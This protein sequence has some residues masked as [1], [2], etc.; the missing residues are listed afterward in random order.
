MKRMFKFWLFSAGLLILVSSAS[1]QIKE[2]D[3]ADAMEKFLKSESGQEAIGKAAEAYFRN[4]EM[5][6][7]QKQ[8]RAMEE[9]LEEQ[10]KNP[11]KIEVGN[12]PV[13]G[14]KDARITVIEFSDYQCPYCRRGRD[15]MR[16]LL[17]AYPKD[18]K[19]VFKNLPL[20]RHQEGKI[21]A[22]AA[23]AAGKQNKFWEMHDLLFDN[24]TQLNQAFYEKAATDLGL[25]VEQFK[26]DMES[27][28]VEKQIQEDMKIAEKHGIQGT[29]GFF[30]NGV[31]VRGAYPLEHFKMIV[32]RWLNK[33]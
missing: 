1:A 32:D 28:E 10:F 23:L 8:A 25:N 7:R 24:Q 26:K 30:V 22:K 2:K 27:P 31:A 15:T 3:F 33:K 19:V 18:V 29:P 4:M 14:P 17:A 16:E 13:K 6:A 12:S 9:E 21:A 11:V 5:A 20:P